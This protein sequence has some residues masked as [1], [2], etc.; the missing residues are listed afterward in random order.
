[1]K[2]VC[3]YSLFVIQ[4]QKNPFHPY[5]CFNIFIPFVPL[6]PGVDNIPAVLIQMGGKTIHS[7][8]Y[9]H[10]TKHVQLK[11]ICSNVDG[12]GGHLVNTLADIL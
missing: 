11:P 10:V 8:V 3:V 4:C 9:K 6:M 1:M 5:I 12:T 2:P 7:E